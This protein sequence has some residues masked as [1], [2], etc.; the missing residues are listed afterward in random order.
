MKTETPNQSAN[1]SARAPNDAA[2]PESPPPSSHPVPVARW[3]WLPVPL[4]LAAMIG[5]WVADPRPV[6]ESQSLLVGMNFLFSTLVSLMVAW[7]MGRG[8]LARPAPGTLLLGCGVLIWGVGSFVAP[9]VARGNSNL[10][11]TIHNLCV[12]LA[13]C[14]HLTGVLLARRPSRTVHAPGWWLAG[15]Y[16]AAVAL[17][18]LVARAATAGAL[19]PFFVPGRGGTPVRQAVLALT[20][21]LLA[22]SALLLRF[23]KG[24]PWSAFRYWYALAL[25][26]LAA[27]LF[28]ILLEPVHGG[29]LSWAGRAAQYLGGAYM[30]MAALQSVREMGVWEISLDTARWDERLL[31]FLTP[32]YFY[33]LAPLSRYALASLISGAATALRWALIPYVGTAVPHSIGLPAAMVTTMLLGLGPGLLSVLLIVSGD[34]VFILGSASKLFEGATLARLGLSLVAGLFI[35]AILHAVRVSQAKA[36]ANATR[37]A[38]LAAATFEGIVESEAGRIVDCNEPFARMSGYSV[39]ELKG[40]EVASLI[41]PEDRER[42]AA[43]IV[44]GRDSEVEHAML[45]KDGT[46]IIV[47]AR[48]RHASPGSPKRH[49]ALRDITERK[50]AQ[51]VLQRFEL[52]ARNTRD[53]I[54]F[55]R[56]SDGR[57]LDANDAAVQAYGYSRA[58]LR[59]LPVQALRAQASRP[60]T[61]SQMGAADSTGI[62]FETEHRCKNGATFPVEV[63]SRGTS[64]AGERVLLSVIRDITERKQAEAQA[65]ASARRLSAV[66]EAQRAIAS[67]NFDYAALLQ[68]IFDRMCRLTGA[69]GAS[70]EVAA[71]GAMVYEAAAG[72]AASFVGLR[73]QIA[74]SLSGLCLTSGALQRADDTDTDPRVDRAACQRLG[75]RSMLLIPLHYAERSFGVFKLMSSRLAAFD[76]PA[77]QTLRLM[78]EFLGVIIARQRAQEALRVSEERFR[79]ALHNSPVSVAVQDCNL[80]YQWAYNQRTRRTDEI[81]GRTDA[82][83]FTPEDL[84]WILTAKRRVLESGTEVHVANWLTSNGQ[85]IF[86]DLYYE[87]VRNDAGEITGVGVAA[88][89]LTQQKRAEEALAETQAQLQA[90]AQTLE[91]TVVARTAK[92]RETVADLEHFSYAITHDMRAPLRAMQGFASIMDEE[93]AGCERADNHEYLRRIQ[94]AATRLDSLITDSLSYAKTV[95]E[96][97]VL[98]PVNLGQLIPGLLLTY[99]NLQPDQA[100]IQ[101]AEPLPVVFGNTAALTQCFSNLLGNAVKFAKPNTKPHI[102]VWAEQTDAQPATRNPQPQFVRL[103]VEDDG[104]GIS[105]GALPRIFNLFVRATKDIEGTGLGLAIVKKVVERMGGRVGVESVEGQ[106]SRFWVDLQ[107]FEA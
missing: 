103:W 68:F 101:L 41:A 27:G 34:E 32:E 16:A 74:G 105:K 107:R 87:P 15:T 31:R 9:L 71:D 56:R 33:A 48:G 22:A 89:N 84:P 18:C 98:E 54:L 95:R 14:G 26:L 53:I 4:L 39:A 94:I 17:A 60:L 90:H 100:D 21:A 40:V 104:T 36:R 47:E 67:A 80:V 51:E 70:L 106:G 29:A 25:A 85:H 66:F 91:Q 97:I 58:E 92:L 44:Q 69:E 61:E 2:F 64:L 77:E 99:P 20:I 78:G 57:V 82:D 45:H 43:N 7:L 23:A 83:L 24:R 12:F 88:V 62:L 59:S 96:Q 10:L 55:V 63:S 35:T 73:L 52:L 79:L 72:L 19:P 42:V 1:D 102:R 3:A 86:L 75:L 81:L 28:G 93:C 8:F 6:W 37:W 30:L 49:T 11:V 46:R 76:Q 50:R 13:A 65:Q 5:I 38:A